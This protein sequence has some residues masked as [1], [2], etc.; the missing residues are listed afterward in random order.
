MTQQQLAEK[1]AI[2]VSY[3]SHLERGVKRNPGPNVVNALADALDLKGF[4][5][6]RLIHE[7]AR[8]KDL[9]CDSYQP[10]VDL[11]RLVIKLEEGT[12]EEKEK[13]REGFRKLIE[14]LYRDF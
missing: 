8:A 4:L 13:I 9:Q 5:R 14:E 1:A 3:V 12:S 2:D 11:T 10:H 7:A 6:L